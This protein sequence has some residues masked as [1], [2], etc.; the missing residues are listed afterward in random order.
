M[1][2]D[3]QSKR[4]RAQTQTERDLAGLRARRDRDRRGVQ[5]GA[6]EA[7][8]PESEAFAGDTGVTERIEGDPDLLR[9]Y[10]KEEHTRMML[11]TLRREAADRDLEIAGERPPSTRFDAIEKRLKFWQWM[12][13][14]IAVPAI[15]SAILV[16]KYLYNRGM[17]DERA[18]AERTIDHRSIEDHERRIRDA[19]N[20][21]TETLYRIDHPGWTVGQPR[22]TP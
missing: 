15:S 8:A 14:A 16:G 4:R 10:Q 3:D 6:S 18:R 11:A 7:A 20:R 21:L 5:I 2:N 17:E 19:E 1:S 12:I 13:M 22:V 9:L